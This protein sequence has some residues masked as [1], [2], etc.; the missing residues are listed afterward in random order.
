MLTAI[1]IGE[2][3]L[4]GEERSGKKKKGSVFNLALTEDLIELEY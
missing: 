2:S 4:L 3:F 1:I